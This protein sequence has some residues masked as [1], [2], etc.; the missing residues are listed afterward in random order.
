MAYDP[1]YEVSAYR[2]S[3]A[4]QGQV[5]AQGFAA[6]LCVAEGDVNTEG[7]QVDT[8]ESWAAGL[9][10][11]AHRETLY[12]KDIHKQ[13]SPA[14][15]TKLMTAIVALTYGNPDDVITVT[16]AVYDITEE[17]A[18]L[19]GLKEGDQLTLNQ[20]MHALLMKS[21]NDA[22]VAIAV[23]IAGSVDAFSNLM[24]QQ[25]V[26]IGA[27]NSHFVN[28]H[29]L[30]AD[31]HYVTAYDLYLIF[32][33]ALNF[34]LITE[35]IQ[36][37][38]YDTVYADKDGRERS[39]SFTTTNQYLSGNVSSPGNVSVIGGK[40]GTTNAARNCLIL[41]ARDAAGNPYIAVILGCSERGTLYEEMSG[42][43]SEIPAL[44]AMVQ[45]MR[46]ADAYTMGETP[47]VTAEPASEEGNP[48]AAPESAPEEE[49]SE[50]A[51]DAVSGTVPE[52]AE[53]LPSAGFS[54]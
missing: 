1:G 41:L 36:K 25:A 37:T 38:S 52:T 14:S 10:D 21:A 44:T 33:E 18:T 13:L 53:D 3:Q 48:D 2:M 16:D 35:I 47:D 50:A 27:T 22:A 54:F 8:S 17:G 32:N 5:L 24:N 43:L 31:G 34:P 20:A 15:L 26:A 39:F 42:M 11:L 12:A 6:D 45:V 51:S 23:H 49:G 40:T 46:D 30:T 7:S 9:F 29:G 4:A 19:A 28:P